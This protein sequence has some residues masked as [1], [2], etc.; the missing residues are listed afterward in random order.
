VTTA[1]HVQRVDYDV[2][3]SRPISTSQ[4]IVRRRRG[5]VLILRDRD[6]VVG[7]GE[8]APVP[9]LGE[10]GP[11]RVRADLDQVEAALT[12]PVPN[13]PEALSAWVADLGWSAPAAHAIEQALLDQMARR[14]GRTL[15][16]LLNP[17]ARD[18]V[19]THHL[20]HDTQDASE[21]ARGG[22]V[23][24]KLKVGAE[25][26]DR[27]ID[28]VRSLRARIGFATGLRL[29]A[30]GAW[31]LAEAVRVL[32]AFDGLGIDCI[33]EPIRGRD[34][35]AMATLRQAQRVPI[36]ADES[37]RST[38]DLDRILQAGAADVVVI[39]PMLVGGPVV[40]HRLATEAIGAGLR[41][42]ITTSLE[43]AVGRTGALHVAAATEGVDV[44]GLDT[45][46][47]WVEDVG[48]SPTSHEGRMR[49]PDTPGLGDRCWE[50]LR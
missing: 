7:V 36:A 15:A 32:S 39:K 21:A 37:V 12:D 14:A 23:C 1:N 19:L 25:D 8:A 5:H 30:N 42:Y 31:S 45:A 20:V 22:A 29:D 3:L 33:E 13:E 34:L 11:D 2:P 17:G 48:Q 43:G 16:H 49:L 40:A 50:G 18:E 9:W 35:A 6:G 47:L 44:C 27:D 24:L 26:P 28:R 10:V 38:A 41:A 46:H 4:G